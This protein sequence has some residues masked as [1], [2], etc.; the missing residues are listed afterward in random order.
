[1]GN[2]VKQERIILFC[3]LKEP[4]IL[5]TVPKHASLSQTKMEVSY[6]MVEMHV[7]R[8]VEFIDIEEQ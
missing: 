3:V 1:M 7:E 4:K 5:P 8:N 2:A 6:C